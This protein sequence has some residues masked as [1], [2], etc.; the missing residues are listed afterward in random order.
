MPKKS[1][2]S[3]EAPK[4]V[5]DLIEDTKKPSRRQRQKM[6]AEAAAAPSELEKAKANALDLFSEEGKPKARK[7]AAD[8]KKLI[9]GISKILSQDEVDPNFVKGADIAQ[10]PA[11]AISSVEESTDDSEES[12]D[13]K[14]IVIKPPILVPDLAARLG[15]KPFNVMADLI[16]LGVFPAPNQPL[17]PEI[18][19]KVCEIHGF[20]FEREKRDKEKGFLRLFYLSA[21]LLMFLPPALLL[22]VIFC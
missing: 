12:D 18:A 19:A 1:D 13:P 16:K 11:A 3:P 14:L 9:G 4:K 15:L 5:L 6:E 7:K 20:T 10:V 21:R 17:E 22:F 8:P 2:N